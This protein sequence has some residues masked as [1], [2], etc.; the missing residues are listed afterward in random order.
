MNNKQKLYGNNDR[1]SLFKYAYLC[2]FILMNHYCFL[3]FRILNLTLGCNY[4]KVTWDFISF[5]TE[6]PP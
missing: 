5:I 4:I 1:I 6:T 3:T 2:D